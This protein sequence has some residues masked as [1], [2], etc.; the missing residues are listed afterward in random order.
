M[1]TFGDRKGLGFSGC[2]V[3]MREISYTKGV[4]CSGCESCELNM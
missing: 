1:L 4:V 3:C 2:K